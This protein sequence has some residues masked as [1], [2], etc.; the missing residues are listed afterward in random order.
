M[1]LVKAARGTWHRGTEHGA[2]KATPERMTL[3]EICELVN[4]VQLFKCTR[5][6]T[7]L[8]LIGAAWSGFCGGMSGDRQS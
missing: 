6:G 5:I 2:R 8:L 7:Q 4:R 3:P 1:A